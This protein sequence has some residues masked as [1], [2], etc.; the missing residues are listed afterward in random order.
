MGGLFMGSA[1]LIGFIGR[2]GEKKLTESF[3][4]GARD[5]LGVA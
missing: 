2:L 1:I 5:L 4:D 3:V